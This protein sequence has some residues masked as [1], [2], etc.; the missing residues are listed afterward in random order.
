MGEPRAIEVAMQCGSRKQER[1]DRGYAGRFGLYTITLAMLNH[2]RPS[3]FVFCYINNVSTMSKSI[4]TTLRRTLCSISSPESRDRLYK[5]P[6]TNHCARASSTKAIPAGSSLFTD[7]GIS[8]CSETS[9]LERIS[10]LLEHHRLTT[11]GFVIYRCTYGD[12][13]AW[14][15][16]M[17]RTNGRRGA[18]PT[19]KYGVED[20]DDHTPNGLAR[21][22]D[23]R[24]QED[25]TTL[26]GASKD[27][28]RRKFRQLVT[29]SL[30][31]EESDEAAVSVATR[32]ENP[33]WNFCVHVD[34]QALD[35]VLQASADADGIRGN[36]AYVNLI[37][38]DASW[39]LPDYDRFNWSIHSPADP[40]EDEDDE[41]DEFEDEI[42][43]SRLFDVGWVKVRAKSLV[44]ELYNTLM[45]NNLWNSVYVRPPEISRWV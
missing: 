27:E 17:D 29:T 32:S 13:S 7:K 8:Y 20:P 3:A 12:D 22:L 1:R 43:R 42:A 45:K 36:G 35:S 16:F 41:Y 19:F 44:P 14:L 33:R 37:R 6:F 25:P 30:Q 18:F 5:L 2:S 40:E 23:W 31:P 34:R 15:S 39:D 9:M 21:R 11:W 28:V 10:Q 4:H 24:V 38:A 26:D